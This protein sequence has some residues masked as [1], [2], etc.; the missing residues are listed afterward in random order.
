M[1]FWKLDKIWRWEEEFVGIEKDW[2]L[3]FVL[4]LGVVLFCWSID[5]GEIVGKEGVSFI[6]L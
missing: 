6:S 3:G 2:W 4:I 5:V 1:K